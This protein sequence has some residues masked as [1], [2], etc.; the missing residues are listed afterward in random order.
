MATRV[1]LVKTSDMMKFANKFAQSIRGSLTWSRKLRGSVKLSAVKDEAGMLVAEI[2]V[3]GNDKNLQGMARAFEFGSG[4]HA[5][6]RV[7]Y[8]I[9]PKTKKALSFSSTIGG[10][11]H[12]GG[13][14]ARAFVMHPGVNARPFM[15]KARKTAYKIAKAE[16]TVDIRKN[17]V[18]A[19]NVTIRE[20]N[21]K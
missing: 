17:L 3:G 9:E 18:D 14:I 11:G 2:T 7:R 6:K 4:V 1:S 20:I 13:R 15:A 5:G 16:L 10:Q 8:K 12:F 19:F 21:N